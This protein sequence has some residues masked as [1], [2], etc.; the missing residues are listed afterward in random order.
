MTR[1]VP[2]G[3]RRC[4]RCKRDLLA[5]DFPTETARNCTECSIEVRKKACVQCH[6]R[7]L[8]EQFPFPDELRGQ[9]VRVPSLKPCAYRK[10]KHA[11]HVRR[12]T[13]CRECWQGRIDL[14]RYGPRTRMVDGQLMRTC[15]ECGLELPLD[16]DHYNIDGVKANGEIGLKYNC[17]ECAKA[18]AREFYKRLRADPMRLVRRKASD[19]RYRERHREQMRAKQARYRARVRADPARVAH[20]REMAR[21]NY[22]LKRILAGLPVKVAPRPPSSGPRLPTAPLAAALASYGARNGDHDEDWENRGLSS[23]EVRAYRSGE[24]QWLAA[25]KADQYLTA[26]ALNWWDVWWCE[27]HDKLVDGCPACRGV[28][29]AVRAFEGLDRPERPFELS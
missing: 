3:D 21:M 5:A 15:R 2:T 16:R 19:Q 26:L 17:K 4:R 8:P 25:T 10:R 12:S 28:R 24:R 22:R 23:R 14:R 1:G 18:E 13:V 20:R 9:G 11:G 27:Q 7:K 6:E 29:P